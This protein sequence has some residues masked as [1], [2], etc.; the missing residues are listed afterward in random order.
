MAVSFYVLSLFFILLDDNYFIIPF[1]Y[2]LCSFELY[3]F[4]L[5]LFDCF[6]LPILLTIIDLIFFS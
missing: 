6:F 5:Y 3:L 4:N 1:I 2:Y